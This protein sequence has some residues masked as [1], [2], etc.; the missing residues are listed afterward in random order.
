MKKVCGK[1][2]IGKDLV[3]KNDDDGEKRNVD[4]VGMFV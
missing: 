3:K 2:K 1:K 4:D